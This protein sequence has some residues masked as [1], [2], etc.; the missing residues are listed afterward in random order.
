MK[1]R[2]KFFSKAA[3]AAGVAALGAA[4]RP[5]QGAEHLGHPSENPAIL[6]TT[7]AIDVLPVP[8]G[9]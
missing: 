7:R 5:V 6:L 3:V 9:P 8:G 2:R 1:S 4:T